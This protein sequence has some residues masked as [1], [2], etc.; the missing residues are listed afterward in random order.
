MGGK[1]GGVREEGEPYIP[2]DAVQPSSGNL[3]HACTITKSSTHSE[4]RLCHAEADLLMFCRSS[5]LSLEM[6]SGVFR[7][8]LPV[9]T[10]ICNRKSGA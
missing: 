4:T 2:V 9:R 6:H 1:G 8:S 3:G 5:S 7:F 10:G